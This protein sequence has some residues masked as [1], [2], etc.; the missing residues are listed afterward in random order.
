MDHPEIITGWTMVGKVHDLESSEVIQAWVCVCL[1]S[2]HYP[3]VSDVAFTFVFPSLVSAHPHLSWNNCQEPQNILYFSLKDS[4][5]Q[6]G[7]VGLVPDRG[8]CQH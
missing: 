2:Q 7:E 6:A 4:G 1:V 3:S 8:L 5:Q